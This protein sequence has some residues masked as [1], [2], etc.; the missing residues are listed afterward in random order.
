MART[1]TILLLTGDYADRLN[2]LYAAAKAAEADKSPR[3]LGDGDPY[4]ELAAEYEALKAEAEA[5]GLRVVLRDPG[6][7]RFRDLRAKHPPRTGEDVDPDT[8]KADRLAGMNIDAAEDDLLHISVI[9]PAFT[10]RA[11]FDEWLDEL[12]EGEFQTL[13]RAAWE[14]VNVAQFDPKSLPPLPT[15][16]DGG[17]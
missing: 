3:L 17:S 16:N 7:K 2:V 8:V 11:G 1:R 13:L 6:R 4:L 10:S 15:R 14:L 9:E 12:G 5:D